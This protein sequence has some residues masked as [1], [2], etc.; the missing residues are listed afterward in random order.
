MIDIIYS[1]KKSCNDAEVELDD[2][3][4]SDKDHDADEECY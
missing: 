1:I 2:R 3:D 4:T